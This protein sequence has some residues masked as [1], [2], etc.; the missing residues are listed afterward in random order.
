MIGCSHLK[1]FVYKTLSKSRI[2]KTFEM[3]GRKLQQT[4]RISMLLKQVHRIN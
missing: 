3:D 2:I 1:L 4:L